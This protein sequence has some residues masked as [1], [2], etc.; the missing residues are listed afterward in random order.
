MKPQRHASFKELD[1]W[2]KSVDAKSIR[3]EEM[4]NGDHLVWISINGKVLVLQEYANNNGW[5]AFVMADDT[6][7]IDKT[8]EALDKWAK[9]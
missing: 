8:I 4:S 6:N 5:E 9:R 7:R 2:L 1:Q 3:A